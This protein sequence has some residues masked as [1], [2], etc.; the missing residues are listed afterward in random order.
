MQFVKGRRWIIGIVGLVVIAAIGIGVGTFVSVATAQSE[1]GEL[2]QGG[3]LLDQAGI[4]IE[5]AIAA[6]QKARTGT[7]QE[8]ELEIERGILIFE[9]AISGRE[10]IVD[11]MTGDVLGTEVESGSDD[12]DE[13][14][15][16]GD[17]EDDEDSDEIGSVC[18]MSSESTI[19]FGDALVFIE[20]NST[21]EDVGFHATF[22]APGWK[23][24]VICSPDG[25]KLVEFEAS[26]STEIFG[27]S[28]LFFEGAEPPLTEQPL[29]EFLAR[30][31]EGEYIIVGETVEGEA[32]M[33]TATFTHDIPDGPVMISPQ[34]DE[35]VDPD[36][37][38][39]AWE[40]VTSPPGIEIARY[41][42]SVSPAEDLVLNIDLALELPSTVTEVQIPP[43][44]LVAGTYEFE[45]LA[46]EVSGNK[47]ITAGEFVIVSEVP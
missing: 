31:P 8:V 46:I 6:T 38:I 37:A 20:F 23:E 2:Q 1:P 18:L 42:L 7:L 9:V 24:A 13:A 40:P 33:S 35:E 47:T 28:E 3:H 36:G 32:L 25:S 41:E 17:V 10:V 4:T 26:G 21:D 5:E 44:F 14:S 29:D 34:E 30:F 19:P 22:D 45:V 39:I 11:A 12:D 16:T 15:E 43:E 27:L